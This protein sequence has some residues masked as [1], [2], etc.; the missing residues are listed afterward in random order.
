MTRRIVWAEFP[1]DYLSN[2]KQCRYTFKRRIFYGTRQPMQSNHPTSQAEQMAHES[3]MDLTTIDAQTD[4][5]LDPV[6]IAP[7]SAHVPT[8]VADGPTWGAIWRE[9]LQ[10]VLPALALAFI[11]HL[12]LAQATVVY[13]QS[14]EPNLS[15]HQRLIVDKLSYRFHPP[16]RNDIVVLGLPTMDEMLVKRIVGLPGET[17]EIHEGI[18]YVNG[19]PLPEP[20]PHDV[21][22]YDMESIT[23]PP[24]YYFVLGDNRSNSNDSRSFGPVHREDILGR[25]WLR[26]WPLDQLLLF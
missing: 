18:V 19:E 8:A 2:P 5:Q 6:V 14:M 22:P 21:T 20:F 17:V 15:Q 7:E 25:V 3:D 26:Y 23:L 9:T 13:G 4:A 11:V 10:V 1:G 16:D 12:F 24:L